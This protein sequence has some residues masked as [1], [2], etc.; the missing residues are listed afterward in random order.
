MRNIIFFT[1][2]IDL[3]LAVITLIL[4]IKFVIRTEKELDK[5][6]KL[7]VVAVSMSLIASALT[8]NKYLGIASDDLILVATS[9]L[10]LVFLASLIWALR[11][12]IK[13]VNGCRDDK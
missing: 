7:L 8:M 5:A 6:A 13:I 2:S 11:I 1:D 12:F 3:I 10:R 9:L 4:A